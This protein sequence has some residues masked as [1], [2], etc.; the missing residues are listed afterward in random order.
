MNKFFLDS[1][2]IRGLLAT[3]I[4]LVATVAGQQMSEDEIAQIVGPLVTLG[5]LLW[6]AYGRWKASQPLTTKKEGTN[7]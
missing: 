7:V 5:G 1:N 3:L 2:T 6:A 4:G